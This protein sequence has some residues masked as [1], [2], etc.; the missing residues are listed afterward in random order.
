MPRG[1]LLCESGALD[2]T[3][4]ILYQENADNTAVVRYLVVEYCWCHREP[5]SIKKE[6]K[7]SYLP[8]IEQDF[9]DQPDQ[10]AL[11]SSLLTT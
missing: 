3:K 4:D 10:A 1:P 11:F 7:A 6:K 2:N 8:W 9:T 5:R